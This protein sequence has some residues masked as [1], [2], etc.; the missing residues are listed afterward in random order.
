M[1]TTP[2]VTFKNSITTQL[3]IIVLVNYV[4]LTIVVGFMRLA[5]DYFYIK[6][7]VINELSV[8]Q[9]TFAPG[10]ARSIYDMNAQQTESTIAGLY[11]LPSIVGFKLKNSNGKLVKVIG[12]VINDNGEEVKVDA[13]GN[14]IPNAG[15]SKLF[16]HKFALKFDDFGYLNDVGE[17]T[18]YSSQRMIFQK[19]RVGFIFLIINS[20]LKVIAIFVLFSW[21]AKVKLRQPL[22]IL[23]AATQQ[24]D[25][26]NIEDFK[27]DVKTEK[28]NELKILEESFNQMTQKLLLSRN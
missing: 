4:L 14:Q 3:L 18:I 19:L 8:V 28:R 16:S 17:A 11:Q 22:S 27:V 2:V 24:L 25:F 23:T 10:L 9:E 7:S 5:A 21:A 15:V 20:I 6:D 1:S 26:D 12:E 13:L